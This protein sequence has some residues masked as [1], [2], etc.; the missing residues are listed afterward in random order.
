MKKSFA[1]LS[2]VVWCSAHGQANINDRAPPPQLAFVRE[3]I[4]EMRELENLRAQGEKDLVQVKDGNERLLAFVHWATS[5]QMAS[6]TDIYMLKDVKLDGHNHDSPIL[7]A[8]AHQARIDLLEHM[9]DISKQ[10]LRGPQPGVDYS[11]I[12]TDMTESRAALERMNSSLVNPMSGLVF[13]SLIDIDHPDSQ[14]HVSF[15]IISKKERRELVKSLAF[16]TG[17]AATNSPFQNAGGVVYD[18][19][20]KKG[21]KCADERQL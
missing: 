13:V 12:M 15:L 10:M 6:E 8:K 7:L 1:V 17:P 11:Q 4:R 5:V 19:L 14:D 16:T 18:F 2:F 20:V 3:F 21:F 9:K